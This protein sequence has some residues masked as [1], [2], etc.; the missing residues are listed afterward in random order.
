MKTLT[1]ALAAVASLPIAGIIALSGAGSA[2]A[3]TCPAGSAPAVAG[4]GAEFC[5]PRSD[6]GVAGGGTATIG[7]GAST[8]PGQAG[9]IVSG[10]SGAPRMPPAYN[11]PPA[12]IAP[13]PAAP[14][15]RPAAP[16]PAPAPAQVQAPIAPARQ[17]EAPVN[18]VEPPP[19]PQEV[20]AVPVT[21]VASEPTKDVAD[22]SA[23]TP[24][25]TPTAHPSAVESSVPMNTPA[26]PSSS[27]ETHP[28]EVATAPDSL[29]QAASASPL[30]SSAVTI[31]A[32][33]IALLL[34]A[35][36][37]VGRI[38]FAKAGSKEH[39]DSETS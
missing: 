37:A 9:A 11:P 33:L 22:T 14:A 34:L 20:P 31:G 6:G 35:T 39:N 30:N 19:V 17:A 10:G 1:K 3:I 36:A 38:S 28:A 21:G 16:A 15:P 32:G 23:E 13:A 5:A 7:N 29:T 4:N 12:Y 2:F 25:P 24:T 27:P 26:P 18:N 8:V